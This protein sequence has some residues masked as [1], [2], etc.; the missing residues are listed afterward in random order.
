VQSSPHKDL[1]NQLVSSDIMADPHPIR[2]PSIQ[3]PWT[4]TQHPLVARKV[5]KR[6]HNIFI[7]NVLFFLAGT[8]FLPIIYVYQILEIKHVSTTSTVHKNLEHFQKG[9]P[10]TEVRLSTTST[11]QTKDTS[12]T[13][14]SPKDLVLTAFLE[15]PETLNHHATPLPVR[16]TIATELKKITFPNVKN[17]STLM[18]DFPI[19]NYPQQDPF[20]PWIHDMIP[21]VDG[22]FLQFVAQNRRRCH[23]GDDEIDTMKYWEPQISL[24]Q[25]VP[26]VVS[27][28]QVQ[29]HEGA[30]NATATRMTYRLASSFQEA[31][32]NATRFQC[33]FHKDDNTITTMSIF[34]FDYEYVTWR[35]GKRALFQTKGKEIEL[36][37]TS[38]LLFSCPVPEVFQTLLSPQLHQTHGIENAAP[39]MYVDL[40]PIRTPARQQYLLTPEQTGPSYSSQKSFDLRTAFGRSHFLPSMDDAGRWQNLPVCPRTD[41]ASPTQTNN[42]QKPYRMVACTWTSSSY[43]R[44]G[45]VVRVSDS[46]QRLREWVTFHL[47]VGMDHVYIY[48]NSVTRE[49]GTS[50]LRSVAEA[51]PP[52]KLTY[53]VWPCRVCNNNR[54]SHKDPGERSS[55]Y[56]AEASCRTRYGERTEWMTFLDTDEYMVR[57]PKY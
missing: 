51:F 14:G 20:L 9:R 39:T 30:Y 31:T 43:T 52:E 36:F 2:Y 11:G 6:K 38:Q 7:R 15:P 46:A 57:F 13:K 37:W 34:P 5:T 29:Q 45:D 26:V 40:I 19:D 22:T 32:H 42:H 10:Q 23:T 53:H 35:K 24:L 48:D 33:R 25:G 54:P 47:M 16:K 1:S 50:E 18:Q 4:P 17:C 41:L 56:A 21:T 44:R 27:Q 49:G 12:Y 28:T 55:Q 3:L 8:V